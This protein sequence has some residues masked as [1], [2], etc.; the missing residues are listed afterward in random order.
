MVR[1][2]R[3]YLRTT[4]SVD[5]LI[6]VIA[7]SQNISIAKF[8]KSMIKVYGTIIKRAFRIHTDICTKKFVYNTGLLSSVKRR[9]CEWSDTLGRRI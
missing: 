7:Y 9:P 2:D 8:E 3:N 5:F 6:S 4:G 1:Y